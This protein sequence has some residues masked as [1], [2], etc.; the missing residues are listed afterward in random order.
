[1]NGVAPA[2]PS[3]I[4]RIPIESLMVGMYVA[5]FDCS[6]FKTPFLRHKFSVHTPDQIERLKQFGI[7]EVRIDLSRG[8]DVFQ[9]DP[10]T[11]PPPAPEAPAPAAATTAL[12]SMHR[13]LET[14]R[15][16]QQQLARSVQSVFQH[17]AAS[18]ALRHDEVDQMAR[19]IVIVTRTL[20]NPAAFMAVSQAR[21]VSPALGDH[22]LAVCTLSLIL[23]E[24][25]G[26]NPARLHLLATGALLHDIGLL[27]LPLELSESRTPLPPRKREIYEQHPRLGALRLEKQGEF[28]QDVIRIV[29][30]H[31]ATPDGHGYPME[32]PGYST[33]EYSRIVMVADRYNDLLVGHGGKPPLPMQQA[34]SRLYQ[35]GQEY[36]LDDTLVSLLL[37]VIGV[38][39]VYSMVELNTGE[40]A[41]V[42]ALTPGK[43]HQPVVSILTDAAGR[44]LS[45][46]VTVNLA[47][48]VSNRSI[49]RILDDAWEGIPV[50]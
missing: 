22:A 37:K 16:A 8:R 2:P 13:H 36:R 28:P 30:E 10:G 44:A 24:A 40:R 49:A 20:N 3:P 46:P 41:V 25:L 12:A 14:A 4:K 35:D 33:T 23:G 38:Y 39:P 34:L 31:H 29:A 43:S 5:G 17:I 9:P 27:Q 15:E 48:D 7:R 19:E 21:T 32:T 18:S 26:Y 42:T 6:W 47:D 50:Q 1:M 11:G 45:R